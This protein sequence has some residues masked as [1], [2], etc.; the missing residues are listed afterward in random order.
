MEIRLNGKQQITGCT[1]LSM[2][3][4]E[5]GFD[6]DA[7]IAEVNHQVI[8]QSDWDNTPVRDGDQI[9]LLSFVGGG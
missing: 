2:L 9:E 5:A 3:I 7:L 8:K 1:S 4:K 6:S